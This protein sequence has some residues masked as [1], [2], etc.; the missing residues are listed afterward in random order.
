MAK[1]LS[2]LLVFAMLVQIIR[3]FDVY[4]LRQRS[5]AWKIALGALVVFGLAAMV[6]PE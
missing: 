3:P 2:I 4:G 6:R 1:F 5:D